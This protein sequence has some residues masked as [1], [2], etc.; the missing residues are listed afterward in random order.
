MASLRPAITLLFQTVFIGLVY[1]M[2]LRIVF[3][4][5]I[6][7]LLTKKKQ[8]VL[9]EKCHLNDCNMHYSSDLCVL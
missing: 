5:I 7:T 6:T 9:F 8:G 4:L 1:G 2:N 3:Q